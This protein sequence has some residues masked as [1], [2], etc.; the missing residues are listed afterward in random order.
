MDLVDISPVEQYVID[1]VREMRTER[2]ISQRDLAYQADLSNGF[3]ANAESSKYRAKY[4]LNHI[5]TFAVIF[6]CSL[7]DFLPDEPL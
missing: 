6:K 1:K 5:N 3:I 7:K 2:G 4:N